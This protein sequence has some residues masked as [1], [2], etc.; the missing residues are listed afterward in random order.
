MRYMAMLF[1]MTAMVVVAADSARGTTS[2]APPTLSSSAAASELSSLS[3]VKGDD[4]LSQKIFAE[5]QN[6]TVGRLFASAIPDHDKNG[7]DQG[8]H[9]L[10]FEGRPKPCPPPP[11]PPDPPRSKSCPCD[12]HGNPIDK[13]CG[14][15]NDG[16]NP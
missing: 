3:A 13:N 8:G 4:S 16:N 12:S 2:P 15:G 7:C 11:P 1:V 14:K 10:S 6:P 5:V 9:H